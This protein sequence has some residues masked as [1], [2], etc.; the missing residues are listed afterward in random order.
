MYLQSNLSK[1]VSSNPNI[2]VFWLYFITVD[3]TQSRKPREGPGEFILTLQVSLEL[4]MMLKRDEFDRIPL[5]SY[6]SEY[7]G[8]WF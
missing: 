7:Y 5:H 6:M 4:L 3:A 2:Y 1:T 8:H